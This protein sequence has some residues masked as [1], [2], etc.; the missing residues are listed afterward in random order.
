MD[1]V[2]T[3]KDERDLDKL[4]DDYSVKKNNV[5]LYSASIFTECILFTTCIIYLSLAFLEKI[6]PIFSANPLLNFVIITLTIVAIIYAFISVSKIR[7][8]ENIFRYLTKPA[9]YDEDRF[10]EKSTLIN[11]DVNSFFSLTQN[12]TPDRAK[13]ISGGLISKLYAMRSPLKYLGSLILALG[14]LGTFWGLLQALIAAPDVIHSGANGAINEN[15][16]KLFSAMSIAFGSSLFGLIGRIFVGFYDWR[17]GA[18]ISKLVLFIDAQFQKRVEKISTSIS[19]DTDA[20]LTLYAEKT[21]N[22]SNDA[23]AYRKLIELTDQ[24]SSIKNNFFVAGNNNS[25]TKFEEHFSEYQEDVKSALNNFGDVIKAS[26]DKFETTSGKID[27]IL[28]TFM[29]RI[30]DV[31]KD[32]KI[33]DQGLSKQFVDQINKVSQKIDV[34]EAAL[35][36]VI[37]EKIDHSASDNKNQDVIEKL[38]NIEKIQEKKISEDIGSIIVEAKKLKKQNDVLKD[39]IKSLRHAHVDQSKQ[40]KSF[41]TDELTKIKIDRTKPIMFMPVEA[42]PED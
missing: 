17:L 11:E 42:Q 39:D 35:L 24:V 6:A 25:E 23:L 10:G 31:E 41:L 27:N 4:Y 38:D 32:L 40:L 21:D 33:R 37:L 15:M 14:L 36:N 20:P 7:N 13:R 5:S 28:P 16:N 12:V 34:K 1:N 18:L 2:K 3:S 19:D 29:D 30:Q 22:F 9:G 26:T 8:A